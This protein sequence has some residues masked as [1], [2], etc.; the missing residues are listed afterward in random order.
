MCMDITAVV[1]D[2]ICADLS[3]LNGV[4]AIVSL[5]RSV[6][7]SASSVARLL[8]FLLLSAL[9]TLHYVLSHLSLTPVYLP[10][11]LFHMTLD[12]TCKQS[13]SA[14]IVSFFFLRFD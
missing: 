1:L 10:L 4:S 5:S 13:C 11:P 6:L 8:N 9:L 7:L 14:T 3:I 2:S 12:N